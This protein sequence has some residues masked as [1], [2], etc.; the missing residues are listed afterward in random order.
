MPHQPSVEKSSVYFTLLEALGKSGC[1]VCQ[2]MQEASASYL[3]VLFD[4]QVTDVGLRRK[5]RQARGLCNWHS[6]EARKITTAALGVA[7]IAQDLLEEECARLAG[8]QRQPFWRN[9]GPGA[10]GMIARQALLAYLRGWLRRGMCPACRVVVAHERHALETLL[11]FFHDETFARRFEG[12]SGLCLPHLVGAVEL[13]PSHPNLSRLIGMQRS[14]YTHLVAELEEFCRKH[15]YRF[16]HEAWG[17]EADAWLRALEMMSGRAAVFGND[18][19]RSA[20]A[21]ARHPWLADLIDRLVRRMTG[22]LGSK[23]TSQP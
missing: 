18:I 8:L 7:I 9:I 5:L 22:A 2:I 3:N 20:P 17:T 4:E 21:R 15:D 13:H 1:A 10:A 14:K 11:N 6:W 16:S 23:P 19:H 12:S